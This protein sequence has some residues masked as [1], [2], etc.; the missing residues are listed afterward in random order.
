M[1]SPSRFLTKRTTISS[2]CLIRFVLEPI[3][4]INGLKGMF[5][6]ISNTF[7]KYYMN[8]NVY[9]FAV[10]IIRSMF[11]FVFFLLRNWTSVMSLWCIFIYFCKNIVSR[12]DFCVST[13]ELINYFSHFIYHWY[14]MHIKL[15]S[16]LPTRISIIS[17]SYY[18]FY[19]VFCVDET[20]H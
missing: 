3:F 8:Y 5:S 4:I 20:E 11:S 9:G 18:I 15:F 14:M 10:L 2:K 6:L 7:S 19:V 12:D 13:V 16:I 17:C 1:W